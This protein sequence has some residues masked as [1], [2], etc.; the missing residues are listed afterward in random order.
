MFVIAGNLNRPDDVY[1]VNL[2][3]GS[4]FGAAGGSHG[5]GDDK[6]R[7]KGSEL[8]LLAG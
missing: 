3:D 5:I 7:K 8:L 2:V 1:R 6:S 4:G